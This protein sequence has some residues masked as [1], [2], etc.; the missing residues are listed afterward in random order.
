L[1][2]QRTR[3]EPPVPGQ[4]VEVDDVRVTARV[5]RSQKCSCGNVPRYF[6]LRGDEVV[7]MFRSWDLLCHYWGWWPDREQLAR[8]PSSW[9]GPL[10]DGFDER[11]R[12][13][14]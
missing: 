10:P 13:L 5:C 12:S 7:S 2:L 1:A 9:T 11:Q 4:T 8:R 14:F 6:V 3:P